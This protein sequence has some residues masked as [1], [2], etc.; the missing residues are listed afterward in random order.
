MRTVTVEI[1][2]KEYTINE[3]KRKANAKWRASFQTQF[4]EIA[5]LIEGLPAME[6]TTEA[7]A[8]L[9]RQIVA[10]L[11]GSV[12]IM[13][14]LVFSYSPEL[15]AD[16]KTIEEDAYDSEIMQVFTEVLKLAYPFGSL[17]ETLGALAQTGRANL[18][19]SP[20]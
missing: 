5:D 8:Q 6:L 11:G 7:V 4:T 3:K 16:K 18:G 14:D 9:I 13:A 19:T 12:D 10:K 15:S 20:S 2:G 17:A 1:A